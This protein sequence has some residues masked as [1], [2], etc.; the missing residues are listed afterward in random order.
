MTLVQSELTV[1]VAAYVLA[2]IPVGA[3]FLAGKMSPLYQLERTVLARWWSRFALVIVVLAL[4]MS[5]VGL[6]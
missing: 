1:I 3:A 5:A 6:V 2:S 4:A